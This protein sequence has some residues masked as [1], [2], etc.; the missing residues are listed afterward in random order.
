M[1]TFED[2]IGAFRSGATGQA[3]ELALE[4]LAQA[5]DESDLMGQVDALCMLAR[6]AL[7]RGELAHAGELAAEARGLARRAGERRLER[8]PIHMQA[9]ATRMRGAYMEARILYQE[10]I[11]LNL[12]LGE[13]RMVAAEHRNLAYVELHDGQFDRARELF[14]MAAKEATSL[15]YKAL[16]PYLLL[17]AAVIA[18]EA[19][20]IKRAEQLAAAMHA[21]LAES[22]L[23]PDPDDAAEEELLVAQL[24]WT[25]P[26]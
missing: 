1:A 17:D 4:F 18:F 5:R 14:F 7:R 8:M 24:Y 11:E 3:E 19:G 9:A 21:A 20:E 22:G 26:T 10:S 16:E 2:A 13:E 12:Q 23:V 6:V 15:G 25:G